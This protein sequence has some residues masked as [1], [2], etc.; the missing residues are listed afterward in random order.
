MNRCNWEAIHGFDTPGEY[1]RFCAWLE[2]QVTN[3]MVEK[4]PIGHSKKEVPF[5]ADERWFRC[6]ESGEVWRLVAPDA[7]SRGFWT[8]VE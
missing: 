8:E 7:P 1:R 6:K 3:G 5:G 4:I 2:A